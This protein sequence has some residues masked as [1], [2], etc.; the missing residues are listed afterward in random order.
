MNDFLN[1]GP[2]LAALWARRDL[3]ETIELVVA[4]NTLLYKHMFNGALTPHGERE[5]SDEEKRG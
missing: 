2:G 1:A 5:H 3:G 4:A